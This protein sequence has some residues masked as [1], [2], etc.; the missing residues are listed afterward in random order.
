M[1][2]TISRIADRLLPVGFADA[3]CDIPCGIYDP[4]DAIQAAQ[5]VIRMTELIEEMGAP[6]SVEDHNS[7]TRY[8]Q[9]KE[10]HAKKAKDDILVI[11]TDYFKPEHLAAHPQLHTKVWEACKLGSY[12]KQHVDMAKAQEFKAALEEI[13]EAFAETKN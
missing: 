2:R 4:H 5:T 7:F 11:W 6:S 3:H 12:V 13:G 8:V 9:V 1:L 10:E